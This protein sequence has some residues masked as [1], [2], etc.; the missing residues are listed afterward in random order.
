[1][2]ELRGMAWDHPRGVAPL[3]AASEV[4]AERYGTEVRWDARPLRG[5]EEQSVAELAARYDV[6]AIDHPFMGSAFA[7]G[8]LLPLDSL[9]PD[10]FTAE[11]RSA[12][13]GPSWESYRWEGS[14]WAVPV[15]AAAQVAA[16]RQDLLREAGAAVPATWAEVQA[17][18]DGAGRGLVALPANGTHLLLALATV[19]HGLARGGGT[20][21]DLAPAW[22]GEDGIDPEVGEPALEILLRLLAKAHP[23]S[24]ESDP[25]QV[26]ERMTRTDE[27]SYVPVAF[28]YSTYARAD[29]VPRPAVFT[30]VPSPDGR[31]RGG[32]LGGVGLAVSR[33]LADPERLVPFLELVAGAAFQSGPY[34]ACG[35]QPAHRAAWTSPEVNDGCPGFFAPTL[36]ALDVSFVRPRAAWYP[37]FQREGGEV[38]HEAVRAGAGP[39][40]ALAA[41]RRCQQSVREA[42]SPS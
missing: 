10:A 23:M 16:Y 12:S 34:A 32:M 41:L 15:D 19:C 30:A 3:L 35:G 38:L 37:R 29:Q 6:I 33:R 42:Y 8:A 21:A 14:S 2:S 20:G 25:I 4:F 26:F 27:I 22:W 36:D 28:G 39:T 1:M 24:L 9:L 5:F 7:E 18:A 13:V 40:A 17:L 31:L 11:L